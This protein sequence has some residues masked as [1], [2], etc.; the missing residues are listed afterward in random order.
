MQTKTVS[1]QDTLNQNLEQLAQQTGRSID[2]LI[3]EALELYLAQQAKPMPRSMG[4]GASG[5]KNL[6][7]RTEE[8]LWT[9]D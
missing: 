2:E 6:A 4:I 8:L 1:L 7:R 9:E 3:Q 5:M